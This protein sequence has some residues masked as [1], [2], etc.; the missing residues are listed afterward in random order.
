MAMQLQPQQQGQWMSLPSSQAPNS[1]CPRGLEYLMSIDQ[2]LVK[3]KVEMLEA[4]TGFET[5]NKY[6][7]SNIMG[8]KV[9]AM[10]EDSGC[11]MRNCCSSARS[12]DMNVFDNN[13]QEVLHFNRPLACDSCC[14]PCCLQELEVSSPPGTI[15]GVVRQDWTLCKPA[16]TIF[17][18]D[19]TTPVVKIQ[20]PFCTTSFCGGDVE[21]QVL[22][23]AGTK[24]G[25]I[26]KQWSGFIKESLTDA[27][28]FGITFPL[29]LD[30]HVKAT[31]LGA[32]MLIDFMFFEK[33]E[34]DA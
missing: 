4:F 26:K 18:A 13:Q 31:L 14:F 29:N 28:N 8:Q 5:N 20:G 21:F 1:N 3:Q 22:D 10:V 15:I 2:L 9:Y 24:I 27:D 32:L 30:V 16:F 33:T 19:K 7:V 6:V 12:F 34:S 17:G 23:L 25:A 11:C